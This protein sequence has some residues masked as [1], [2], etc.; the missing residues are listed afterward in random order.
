MRGRVRTIVQWAVVLGGAGVM[1]WQLPALARETNDLGAELAQLRWGWVGAA[2]VLGIGALVVYGELHRRLLAAGGAL[3]PVSTIQAINFSQNALSTT[4]PAVGNA[5]G[6]VYATYQLRKRHVEVA[7]AAWSLVLAGTVA[8]ITLIVLGLLGLGWA[9]KV[10]VLVAVGLAA[11][12]ALGSWL[13]WGVVTRPSV[14]HRFLRALT[15]LARRFPGVCR[16]CRRSWAND[17]DATARRISERIRLLRPNGLQWLVITALAVLSWLLD[18][19]SLT[20]SVAALGPPVPWST[21]VVGFL[22]VQ[23]SIALQVFP[24]GAGLA[25]AGLLGVLTASGV[26]VAPALASVLVYRLINWLGLAA[27]GWMVYA[28]QIHLAPLHEHQ[29]APAFASTGPGTP[30]RPARRRWM[31]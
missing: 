27:L 20:T 26:P 8:T 11:G 19:L 13:C 31:T 10:P 30:R 16:T 17:P 9:G 1:L 3:L 22:V 12:V 6:F 15:W 23:G 5:A 21:L 25:E 29:H 28:V 2:V 4:L 18:Y 14:L 7:L 24:G